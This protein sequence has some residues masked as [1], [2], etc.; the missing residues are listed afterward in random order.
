[1]IC[2]ENVLM[3]VGCHSLPANRMKESFFLLTP[4]KVS[5]RVAL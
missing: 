5:G 3:R 1:M 2:L 4:V